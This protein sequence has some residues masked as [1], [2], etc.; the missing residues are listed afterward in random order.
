MTAGTSPHRYL[1][2]LGGVAPE[3]WANA[4]IPE[5]RPA[6]GDEATAA[7][8][9]AASASV[10]SARGAGRLSVAWSYDGT[11]FVCNASV[12]PGFRTAQLVMPVPPGG[13]ELS[14]RETRSGMRHWNVG[15]KPAALPATFRTPS[16]RVGVLGVTYAKRNTQAVLTLEPGSYEFRL[17]REPKFPSRLF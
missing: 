8:L 17:V 11:Q 13:G 5:L 10:A 9:G 2:Q 1:Y 14:L 15:G 4:A 7:A 3:T 16:S 6:A 12:P